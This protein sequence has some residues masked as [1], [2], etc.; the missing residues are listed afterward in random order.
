MICVLEKTYT[1]RVSILS[2]RTNTLL[3]RQLQQAGWIM[4]DTVISK[5]PREIRDLHYTGEVKCKVKERCK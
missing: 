5:V 2:D 4:K 3:V 1:H